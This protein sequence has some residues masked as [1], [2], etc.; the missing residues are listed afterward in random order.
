LRIVI[1]GINYAPEPIGIGPYTTGIAEHYAKAGHQV[2]VVT[3]IPHYPSWRSQPSSSVSSLR[4]DVR[5]YR[6]F[7]PARPSAAGRALYEVTWLLSAIR[8]FPSGKADVAIGVVPTLS[9]AAL[10][11]MAQSRYRARMG[12]IFQD[13]MGPSAQQSG[14]QGGRRVAGLV[15]SAERYLARRA[16]AVA[17]I[18]EGFRSYLE[19]AGVQPS[20]I[21][22]VR[23][24]ARY[25]LPAESPAESRARLGWAASDFICLHT[26]N[27]GR[28]QGLET[29]IES[30]RLLDGSGIRIVLSGDGNDRSR[31]LKHATGIS[32]S[33][34]EFA[35]V[36]GNGRFEAMLRAADVLLLSQRESVAEMNLPSKLGAY[37][38]AGRPVIAA[39]AAGSAA[40]QEVVAAQAGTIVP[41]GDAAALAEAVRTLKGDI[42]QRQEMG[43][44]G[45][46][47]AA[48]HL[49]P[50][51][52]LATFDGFLERLLGE[53]S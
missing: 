24:W 35:P 4:L 12:I 20:R 37:F 51:Q 41:A 50:E 52:S 16:D 46:S 27:M 39:V 32:P 49:R 14:Y 36:Q 18:S 30:A 23:N 6:H 25:Q 17:I 43:R 29:V 9:G 22:R 26:G 11:W 13:L 3:G 7:V 44:N 10:A 33:A 45:A 21:V 47:Y 53:T 8:S 31:L 1:F 2:R 38:A 5:R 42:A 28:K 34:L 40:A 19:R 15:E 48:Q